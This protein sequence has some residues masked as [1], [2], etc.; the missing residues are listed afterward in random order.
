MTTLSNVLR[1]PGTMGWLILAGGDPVPELESTFVQRLLELV[2]PGRTALSL[3]VDAGQDAGQE[4]FEWFSDLAGQPVSVLDAIPANAGV[5]QQAWLEAGLVHLH[6]GSRVAW[7][8]LFADNLFRG[9]PEEILAPGS[10]LLASGA[11]AGALGTWMLGEDGGEISAGVDWLAGGLVLPGEPSPSHI[12]AVVDLLDGVTPAYA[13]GLP[14]GSTLALG[15]DG[16]VGVWSDP[17]PSILLGRG[18][19]APGQTP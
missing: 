12:P 14:E 3:V 6:G 10:V 2:A 1:R 17:P 5:I 9:Y 18:W 11:S 16:E 19:S 4:F 8:E 13:L 15:P 7:R